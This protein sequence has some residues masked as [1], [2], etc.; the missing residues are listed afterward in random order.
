MKDLDPQQSNYKYRK[1]KC[2]KQSYILIL[3]NIISSEEGIS[4]VELSRHHS[5]LHRSD[6]FTNTDMIS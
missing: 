5:K 4:I 1:S 6:W 2:G 3:F